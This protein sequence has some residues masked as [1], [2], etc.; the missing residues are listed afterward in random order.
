MNEPQLNQAHPHQDDNEKQAR[1]V[2]L[3]VNN[4]PVRFEKK[5]ELT[6]LEIKQTAIAQGV[7]IKLDYVLSVVRGNGHSR[8]LGDTDTVKI[9]GNI[10]FFAIPDD[11]NS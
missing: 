5:E 4:E 9:N 7:D 8:Q 1:F 3:P 10:E 2:V 11:D 6:G